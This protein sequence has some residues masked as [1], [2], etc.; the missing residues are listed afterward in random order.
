MRIESELNNNVLPTATSLFAAYPNPFNP[1]TTIN[2]NV[3]ENDLASLVIYNLKGQVVKS[4]TNFLP[5]QHSLVWN[6]KDNNN[7]NVASGVYLYKL[8]SNS[9]NKTNKMI[10]MK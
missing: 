7:K 4:Y 8:I 10:L 2:F 5:G 6:A 9:Y 3:K 1:E